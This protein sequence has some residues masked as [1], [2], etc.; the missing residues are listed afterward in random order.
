MAR[1]LSLSNLTLP[2]E[3]GEGS[4]YERVRK[5]VGAVLAAARSLQPGAGVVASAAGGGAGGGAEGGTLEAQLDALSEEELEALA[6]VRWGRLRPDVAES[7][8][9]AGSDGVV[10]AGGDGKASTLTHGGFFRVPK[11]SA[12]GEE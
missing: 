2:R 8:E 5:D 9:G 1:L 12:S 6:R 11:F 10:A 4:A 3:G 7:E